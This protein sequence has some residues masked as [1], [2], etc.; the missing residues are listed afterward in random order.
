MT[1]ADTRFT[2]ATLDALQEANRVAYA[3]RFNGSPE[4]TAKPADSQ[5]RY[6]RVFMYGAL[7]EVA[8][9]DLMTFMREYEALRE[10]GYT[11]FEAGALQEKTV[12]YA[13]FGYMAKRLALQEEEL[14][15]ENARVEADYRATVEA[16]ALN[17]AE[18]EA[19][20]ELAAIEAEVQ[21]A[22]AAEQ[23]Q[24]VATIRARI[25]GEKATV[26]RATK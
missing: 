17:A 10:Q 6:P 19:A 5:G 26:K 4:D 18:K 15:L 12:G 22:L 23:A 14:A 24:R 7:V 25:L 9:K 21:A 8:G 16:N 20:E 3:Q 13:C 11:R 1:I 2:Q